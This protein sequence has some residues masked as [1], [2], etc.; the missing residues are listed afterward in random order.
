MCVFVGFTRFVLFPKQSFSVEVLAVADSEVGRSKTVVLMRVRGHEITHSA[1]VL[2][3]VVFSL[4]ASWSPRA[5]KKLPQELP[6][7]P[8]ELPKI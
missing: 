2:A 1:V 3:V 6:K 4:S 8:Q 5:P 7:A